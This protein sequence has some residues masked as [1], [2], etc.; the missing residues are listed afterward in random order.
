V[1]PPKKID[2]LDDLAQM[3]ETRH[4]FERLS[5]YEQKHERLNRLRTFVRQLAGTPQGRLDLQ[6]RMKLLGPCEPL[7]DDD[8]VSYY[9]KL[10]RWIDEDL[11]SRVV[12]TA[13][14]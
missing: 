6:N 10:R 4:R 11:T 3:I 5:P 1:N 12:S 14:L 7:P 2:K 8:V 9:G 13:Q